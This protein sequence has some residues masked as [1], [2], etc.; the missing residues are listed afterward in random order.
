MYPIV[1]TLLTRPCYR[2]TSL[3]INHKVKEVIKKHEAGGGVAVK[4]EHAAYESA[5]QYGRHCASSPPCIL[6]H[7]ANTIF[8]TVDDTDEVISMVSRVSIDT[9]KEH[10]RDDTYVSLLISPS[11]FHAHV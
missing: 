11:P 10:F 8:H 4:I 6:A 7:N 2:S 1:A 3:E 5:K 9:M